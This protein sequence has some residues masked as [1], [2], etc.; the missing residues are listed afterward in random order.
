[1]L[2]GRGDTHTDL[3]HSPGLQ[4]ADGWP[5]LGDAAKPT[6]APGRE[7]LR[8]QCAFPGTIHA[9]APH[10]GPPSAPHASSDPCAHLVLSKT[11][12]LPSLLTG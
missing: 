1:M 3:L 10:P 11:F 8:T 6:S 5:Q 7:P 9:V 4:D 2:A 12:F